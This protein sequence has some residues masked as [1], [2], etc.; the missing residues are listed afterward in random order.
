M[1]LLRICNSC[2]PVHSALHSRRLPSLFASS[3]S[4]FL[5]LFAIF[6][7]KGCGG[8]SSVSSVSDVNSRHRS[9]IQLIDPPAPTTRTGTWNKLAS[10]DFHP[11][12]DSRHV[13]F[14]LSNCQQCLLNIIITSTVIDIGGG[15]G[16][17]NQKG[18]IPLYLPHFHDDVVQSIVGGKK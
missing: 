8:E 5:L 16:G 18:T 10:D 7:L 1:L 3:F 6:Y 12:Y 17:I 13:A 11:F 4:S 2:A 15:G 9:R 14:R